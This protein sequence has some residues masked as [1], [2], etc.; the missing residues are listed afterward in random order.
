VSGE[1]ETQIRKYILSQWTRLK[2]QESFPAPQPV[3]IE[4]KDLYK[5]TRFKYVVAEKTDGDRYLLVFLKVG[6]TSKTCFLV[7]RKFCVYT[8]DTDIE[9]GT[10]TIFDGELVRE[11]NTQEFSY[12][13]H[14]CV[15]AGGT[16]ISNKHLP[17]RL[18]SA[19]TY[20]SSP[21]FAKPSNFKVFLKK[22]WP[23]E[24]LN[25]LLEFQKAV[26][27]D[28]DGLIFTPV[29]LGIESGTQYSL[30]KWKCGDKHTIDFHVSFSGRRIT[31]NLQEH[32]HLVKYK[33]LN[34]KL[35]NGR[36]FETCM[37]ALRP[38]HNFDGSILECKLERGM[39]IPVRLREDKTLP[40]SLRTLEKTLLNIEENI[41]LEELC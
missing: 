4:R 8:V 39:F 36:T 34:T 38:G 23:I 35:A 15:N 3:S 33:T 17:F 12:Y 24:E 10:G 21:G 1:T 40:N 32:G 27:H 37:A 6:G 28:V 19:R 5:L 9:G 13:V 41:T 2:N 26:T 20:I 11:K 18:D 31:M 29:G 30:F 16:N 7:D 22:M 25:K 14:D